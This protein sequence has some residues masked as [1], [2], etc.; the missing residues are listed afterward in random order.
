MTTRTKTTII[1]ISLLLTLAFAATI[2]GCGDSYENMGAAL[3]ADRNH[4]LDGG[5]ADRLTGNPGSDESGWS[6]GYDDEWGEMPTKDWDDTVAG[7]N[8]PEVQRHIIRNAFMQVE[9]D[10]SLSATE[11]YA[12]VLARANALGGHES[13]A[14]SQ[15]RERLSTVRATLRIPPEKLDEFMDYVGENAEVIQR[16]IDTDDVT[17]EFYDLQTRL[18]TKRGTLG[19]YFNLLEKAEEPEDIIRVQR[20]ID[21]ITEEIEA[22]EGRMR[23]IRGLTDMATVRLE[24]KQVFEPLVPEA[25]PRREVDWSA[26]SWG[27]VGWLIRNGF[28]TVVSAIAT[29]FQWLIVIVAVTSPLWVPVLILILVLVKRGKAKQAKAREAFEM[30]KK[31]E[32]ANSKK[33][34]SDEIQ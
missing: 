31:A 14:E 5:N 21:T 26:L 28:I 17:A 30:R 16:K 9:T 15:S 4:A 11:L 23:V 7:S 2:T 27:D 19:A 6:G 29:I 3:E 33:E 1:I 18:E 13:A 8:V 25:E 12:L 32:A 10:E 20:I 22:V 34:Q 24:I